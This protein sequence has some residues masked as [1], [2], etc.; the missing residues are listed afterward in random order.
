MYGEKFA[1]AVVKL[2]MQ[3]PT[4]SGEP[5]RAPTY[6]ER[7]KTGPLDEEEPAAARAGEGHVDF[8]PLNHQPFVAAY[9]H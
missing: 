2:A 5:P 1:R 6:V 3:H 4:T 9:G 7:T 8:T